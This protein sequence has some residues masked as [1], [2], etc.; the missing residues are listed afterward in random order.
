MQKTLDQ[1][2]AAYSKYGFHLLDNPGDYVDVA[3]DQRTIRA[4]A[5]IRG[6][7]EGKRYS[8]RK[9]GDDLYRITLL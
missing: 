7:K 3:G 4:S 6:K 2:P 1:K 8:V 5:T 9:Q